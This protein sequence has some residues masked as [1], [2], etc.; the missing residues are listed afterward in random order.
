[1]RK[2]NTVLG[3]HEHTM[4]RERRLGSR[5][6]AGDERCAGVGMIWTPPHGRTLALCWPHLPHLLPGSLR[7]PP[8][9][10]RLLPEHASLL[11]PTS[12]LW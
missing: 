2:T 10:S 6:H 12:F 1:M 9:V 3:L 5:S 7:F 8:Q 11:R 4:E